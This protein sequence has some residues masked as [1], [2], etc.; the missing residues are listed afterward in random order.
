M[1]TARNLRKTYGKKVA[2]ENMSFDVLP[3]CVTGFLGP[4]GA[5]KS[6]TMRLMLGLDAGSGE[7]LFDGK[8]YDALHHP[9]RTVG[10]V[11]EARSFHPRRTATDHLTMLAAANNIDQQQVTKALDMVG[12]GDVAGQ[13]PGRFSLG[14]GQRLGLAGAILGRPKH[15]ILDEPGNGLDPQ[16]IHWLRDFLKQYAAEGNSVFVSSHLL[17]EMNLMADRLVV[18][19]QGKTLHVGDVQSFIA[20]YS[21]THIVVAS[22]RCPELAQL[23]GVNGVAAETLG[24]GRLRLR[25]VDPSAVGQLAAA[26]GL[27]LHELTVQ[28][29]SLEDAFLRATSGAVEYSGQNLAEAIPALLGTGGSGPSSGGAQG[30][31]AAVHPGGAGYSE[32]ATTAAHPQAVAPGNYWPGSPP[33]AHPIPPPLQVALPQ[34][35]PPPGVSGAGGFDT[36]TAHVVA[37]GPGAT[38]G[39]PPHHGGVSHPVQ[40]PYPAQ[41]ASGGHGPAAPGYVHPDPAAAYQGG[42]PSFTGAETDVWQNQHPHNPPGRP[43]QFGYQGTPHHDPYHQGHCPP[44]EPP[45]WDRPVTR[46]VLGFTNYDHDPTDRE[47]TESPLYADVRDHTRAIGIVRDQSGSDGDVGKRGASAADDALFGSRTPSGSGANAADG[48][49]F[50]AQRPAVAQPGAESVSDEDSPLFVEQRLSQNAALGPGDT[51][52]TGGHAGASDAMYAE[53]ARDTHHVDDSAYDYGGFSYGTG[54]TIPVRREGGRPGGASSL[55]SGDHGS[56]GTDSGDETSPVAHFDDQSN[57]WLISE[58]AADTAVR[59]ASSGTTRGAYGFV[60]RTTAAQQ[61]TTPAHRHVGMAP[62][63]VD[64]DHAIRPGANETMPPTS[65]TAASDRR[66]VASAAHR[67]TTGSA[68]VLFG[69]D[70]DN[71]NGSRQGA[72]TATPETHGN[73]SGVADAFPTAGLRMLGDRSP[74]DFGADSSAPLTPFGHLR[75]AEQAGRHKKTSPTGPSRGSASVEP[76][77]YQDPLGDSSLEWDATAP[78]LRL[79]E[80]TPPPRPLP[81]KREPAHT[82]W[83]LTSPISVRPARRSAEPSVSVPGA[84]PLAPTGDRTPPRAV[85]GR[86]PLT[87]PRGD[88]DHAS[89]RRRDPLT[90]PDWTPADA[91]TP[92]DPGLQA[93]VPQAGTSRRSRR[94]HAETPM[95]ERHGRHTASEGGW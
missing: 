33:A 85:P 21:T 65:D 26:H 14:M 58:S 49:L 70:V 92:G 6:T 40:P 11:L 80:D 17:S 29:A 24:D 72:D 43:R 86:D 52:P 87:A 63:S 37:T 44:D 36:T 56:G 54:P 82:D 73:G 77:R 64:S 25:G 5:G 22:P 27:P 13:R 42:P 20:A 90:D 7:T 50:G 4:N 15:L 45:L 57:L 60:D 53:G 55:G 62:D 16:G 31:V 48:A 71:A 9:M 75:G 81:P 83:D 46:E 39:Q 61:H 51:K 95:G 66:D 59:S 91:P 41:G 28:T 68:H 38:S 19:G 35:A 10:A 76:P 30:P 18:I 12:L 34:S 89:R 69:A 84:D 2:V 23:M 67:T 8:P 93:G 47:R 78:A 3:G 79:G 94:T 1:I 88:A 32:S 74:T